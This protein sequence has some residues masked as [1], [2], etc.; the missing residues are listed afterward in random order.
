MKLSRPLLECVPNFSEGRDSVRIAAIADAV[1]SVPG[2]ALLHTDASPAANRTVL[3]FAG[4]PDAVGEAAFRAV[5][6]AAEVI[7]MRAQEG[8][9][10]RIGATDVCPFV[11]L[12]GMPLEDALRVAEHTA[13][14]VGGE[15]GIPVYLYEHNARA[16]HRR[17]LPQIRRGSYE[18]L[19]QK[20]QQPHWVPDYG[21]IA[22]N[23]A[24]GAT[25]M[26]VRD[27]LVAFNISLSTKDV[28]LAAR[29]ARKLRAVG[30]VDTSG[31][32]NQVHVPGLLPATRAIGWYMAD[33]G[34]AQVSF[35]LLDYRTTSP[36]DAFE[37]CRRLAE[38]EGAEVIGAEVI[39]LLPEECLV[40]AGTFAAMRDGVDTPPA[41]DR[42][43]VVQRGIHHMKLSVLKPFDPGVQVLERAL[44]AAGLTD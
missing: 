13:A 1:R 14:R 6:A 42:E 26:G 2:V 30:G 37:A 34:T 39:G 15:L 17:E 27:V 11:P 29:I 43:W 20:M 41:E 44:R 31:D 24:A 35:N 36:L 4:E 16:P 40:Q 23:A 22:F 3:T 38:E 12:G 10:P 28:G 32:G 9:H 8:V 7:D 19:S 33:Y 5:R 18:G 25:V 21:P